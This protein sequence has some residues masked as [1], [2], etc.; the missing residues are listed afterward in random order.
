MKL[1]KHLIL[2]SAF[3]AIGCQKQLTD[4]R[5]IVG[6][7]LEAIGGQTRLDAIRTLR[8]VSKA[9]MKNGSE[10]QLV[11][12]SMKPDSFRVDS[13]MNGNSDVIAVSGDVGFVHQR[14]NGSN[15]F[16]KYEKDEVDSLRCLA[17][18]GTYVTSCIPTSSLKYLGNERVDGR[19]CYR[20]MGRLRNLTIEYLIDSRT[21]FL[22]QMRTQADGEEFRTTETFRDYYAVSGVMFPRTTISEAFGIKNEPD[23]FIFSNTV[24]LNITLGPSRFK[25]AQ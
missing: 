8:I 1:M 2:L 13:I 18:F 17:N 6:R 24:E 16:T 3:V 12:E 20:L 7:H 22:V 23:I 14:L 10:K 11:S 9:K 21:Y 4:P 5:Q 19:D 25:L 15:S